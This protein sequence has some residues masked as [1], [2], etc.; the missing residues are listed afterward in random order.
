MNSSRIQHDRVKDILFEAGRL[1][2]TQRESYLAEACGGDDAL[3]HRVLAL[4]RAHDSATAFLCEAAPGR[5]TRFDDSAAAL[6]P[7]MV[8]GPYT[9][10]APLGEGGFGSVFLA[11][12]EAPL[13]RQVAIKIIRPGMDSGHVI[14]R[15]EAER[16]ALAVMDHAG[17]A[18]VFDA[19]ATPAGRP[20]F[21]MEY[22][23]GRPITAFCDEHRLTIAERLE[24]VQEVCRAVQHA[25]QKGIIHRDIKPSN[26][27]V[28]L[29]DGRPLPKVIDFGIAKAMQEDGAGAAPLTLEA[30]LL[31]TPQY[32][33]PEQAGPVGAVIDTRTDVYSLGVLLYQLLTGVTPFESDLH[34]RVALSEFVR[35]LREVDPPPPSARVAAM[36]A[37][38]DGAVA[39]RRLDGPRLERALRGDLDWIVMRAMEKDPARRYPTADALAADIRRHLQDEPIEAGPPSLTYRLSKFVRRRRVEV[40][41]SGVVVMA[42]VALVI[43]SLWFGL[44]ERSSAARIQAELDR[45]SA[46]S[47]FARSVFTGVDPAKARGADTTLLKDILARA[48][49]RVDAELHDQPASAI[50]MLNTIGYAYLQ[51]GAFPEAESAF[52]RIV[53]L[54]RAP[55]L[56][57]SE[58]AISAR[59]NLA[60][61]LTEMGR[62]DESEPILQHLRPTC[63]RVLGDDHEL[64]LKARGNLAQVLERKGRLSESLELQ[65]GVL[66]ARV[67]LLGPDHEDT[68]TVRNNLAMLH[69]RLGQFAEA[70]DH[71]QA[72]LE[73]QKA[74]L[75]DEHPRTLMTM[76][77]LASVYRDMG[78]KERSAEISEHVLAVKR[79]V[80]E[81]NHP[82]LL[83]SLNNLASLYLDM[84]RTDA[85][86]AM[87]REALTGAEQTLGAKDQRT[88]AIRNG[89]TRVLRRQGRSQEAEAELREIV[90]GFIEL[91]GEDSP[92]TLTL[93]SNLATVLRDRGAFEE[94]ES[95][96]SD[97]R[98]RAERVLGPL[99]PQ[100]LVFEQLLSSVLAGEGRTDEAISRLESVY[101][102]CAEGLGVDDSRCANVAGELAKTFER[103]GREDDARAWRQR[104]GLTVEPAATGD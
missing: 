9:I 27:M 80:L 20:Y 42:L 82:S 6:A 30:Q 32:M 37:D 96:A 16:Q 4:L 5:P 55:D 28:T 77:N 94:A 66:A 70:A 56:V 41:L 83:V 85:A 13:R 69:A 49:D 103:A 79:R 84:D 10:E 15:F 19:G 26:V 18:R 61:A 50:T 64:T 54:T 17:I 78:D 53:D 104:A 29:V 71:V 102:A 31:G 68:L 65:E 12:Q 72:V 2:A 97:I 58:D 48:R 73:T 59:T 57:D 47:A 24:L 76:N 22:V 11:R 23:E 34:Q 3:H 51:I 14:R 40:A 43:G 35:T 45:A 44:R 7:G 93:R 86:E 1:A 89:L 67:R 74:T 21:V 98:D 101:A 33:A 88:L 60:V 81:P 63:E 8:L 39:A 99:A 87:Y 62:L 91:A 36:G 38:G 52:G 46:L 95:I 92:D 25:H 75:G 90:A 100:T